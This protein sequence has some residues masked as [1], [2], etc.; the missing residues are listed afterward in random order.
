MIAEKVVRETLYQTI[1]RG[2]TTISEDVK[3][4]FQ[5]AI[6]IETSQVA[7]EGLKR[8]YESSIISITTTCDD[9]A[10]AG[11]S[12]RTIPGRP[13]V[14]ML[15]HQECFAVNAAHMEALRNITYNTCINGRINNSKRGGYT[16]DIPGVFQMGPLHFFACEEEG[17]RSIP[18]ESDSKRI[19][20][21]IRTAKEA[22]Q[23]VLVF[24]HT[25]EIKGSSDEEPDYFVEIFS[26]QC[27]DAGAVAV[28]CS[29]THQIKAI[30]VY[31]KAPIFYSIA[32]FIFKSDS[33]AELPRDFYEKYDVPEGYSAKEALAVRSANGTRG[34]QCDTKNYFGLV[35]TLYLEQGTVKRLVIQPTELCF[36]REDGLKGFPRKAPSVAVNTIFQQLQR[37]SRPYGTTLSLENQQIIISL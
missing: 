19:L 20:S 29:G 21:A 28:I 12:S 23:N 1:V 37:L 25:H 14:N 5:E 22:T 24:L 27:I 33:V 16:K 10:R 7:K 17:K 8:T 26:R 3:A 4:A 6:R 35:P 18:N 13:G 34:L 36:D 11:N 9:A 30:E 2:A 32:N 31:R 15:R